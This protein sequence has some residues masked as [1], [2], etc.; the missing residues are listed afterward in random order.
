MS[1]LSATLTASSDPGAASALDV[2]TRDGLSL[3][4][5]LPLDNDLARRVNSGQGLLPD[6]DR[7]RQRAELADRLGF[8]ALWLRDVPM[9]R[10]RDFGDAGQ[11]FDPVPYLGYLAATTE[12]ILLG[13][14][15]V[16][17]PLRN[18]VTLAKEAASIDV[19]SHGRLLLGL[20]SGD[21][22]A[23]YP[24]FGVDFD[25][26]GQAYR[27]SVRA[28]RETWAHASRARI[29]ENAFLPA[30]VHG[31]IPLIGIGGAQQAPEWTAEHLDAFMTY[32]RPAPGLPAVAARWRALT[33]KPF[34]TNLY[35]DL[36]ENPDA[37]FEAIRLGARVGTAGLR[38]YLQE[39]HTAGIAHVNLVL[40]PGRRDV[41]DVMNELGQEVLP[42]LPV[43]APYERRN[44]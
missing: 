22:P 24:Y 1:E 30:P 42:K 23:E 28:M 29:D 39:L 12:R 35:L 9:W 27:D 5:E 38:D 17:L 2:L 21:R 25:S 7:H 19:L 13:T 16:V 32:H 8:R 6:L 3:G 15:G 36:A 34:M 33:P 44:Q 31:T 11:I 37:P 40:R 43:A 41:E 26:R 10:P 4:I 18:P 14:A 20:A